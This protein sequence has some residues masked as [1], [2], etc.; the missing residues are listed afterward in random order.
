MEIRKCNIFEDLPTQLVIWWR[1]ISV[2]RLNWCANIYPICK[3]QNS[4]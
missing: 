1:Q 3:H 2:Y 4:N